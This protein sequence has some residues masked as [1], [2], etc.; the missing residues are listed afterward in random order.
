M[1]VEYRFV[2]RHVDHCTANRIFEFPDVAWPIIIHQTSHGSVGDALHVS[3]IGLIVSV[4]NVLCNWKDVLLPVSKGWNDNRNNVQ[5]IIQVFPETPFCDGLLKVDV[6]C[7]NQSYVD[8]NWIG[9]SDSN[10]LLLLKGPQQFRL[11]GG[12]HLADFV[13]EQRTL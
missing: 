13:K 2:K 6:G 12:A 5:A 8:E 7:R 4:Y 1:C 9:P 3:A 11:R 10:Y